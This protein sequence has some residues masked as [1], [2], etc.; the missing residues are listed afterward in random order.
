MLAEGQ[1]LWLGLELFQA[2]DERA[3]VEQLTEAAGRK[4][5]RL[6]VCGYESSA[7]AYLIATVYEVNFHML[8][9]RTASAWGL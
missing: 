3:V 9:C 2:P 5:R 6:T 4:C 1:V 7:R 8:C